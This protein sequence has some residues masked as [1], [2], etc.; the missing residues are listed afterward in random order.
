MIA[1]IRLVSSA[2]RP[3]RWSVSCQSSLYSASSF[4]RSR[5][6]SRPSRISR[7]GWAW[8]GVSVENCSALAAGTPPG[9]ALLGLGGTLAGTD[10]LDQAV[11]V[12]DREPEA[13]DDLAAQPG[14]AQVEQ[15]AA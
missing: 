1:V 3:W 4:S 9:A 6:V 11:D 10:D 5:P 7:I 14:L 8:R 2:S 15:R 13:L 12:D